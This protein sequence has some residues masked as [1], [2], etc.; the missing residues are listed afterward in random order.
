MLFF[1]RSQI[2]I[3]SVPHGFTE[4]FS[5]LTAIDSVALRYSNP[6]TSLTVSRWF[7]TL[8]PRALRTRHSSKSSHWPSLMCSSTLD[9]KSSG[10]VLTYSTS[11]SFRTEKTSSA[12]SRKPIH[13]SS[14]SMAAY[15][16]SPSSML[17]RDNWFMVVSGCTHYH[18]AFPVVV[19]SRAD[20]I[21]FDNL[22]NSIA[23]T[24]VR[25]HLTLSLQLSQVIKRWSVPICASSAPP[26][27]FEDLVAY[28]ITNL[29]LTYSS[30]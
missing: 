9:T 28:A 13:S 10:I 5:V 12:R 7:L 23:E 8:L 11:S 21:P 2:A 24:W 19:Q 26:P 27:A 25:D 4:L 29:F 15:I 14:R 3:P 6:H 17:S 18:E 1:W 22:L 16:H 20:A 30:S